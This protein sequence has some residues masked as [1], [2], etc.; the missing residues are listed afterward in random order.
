MTGKVATKTSCLSAVNDILT[1]FKLVN[2]T[3]LNA[4]QALADARS[5]EMTMI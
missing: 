4:H 1:L 2:N 3:L 5:S